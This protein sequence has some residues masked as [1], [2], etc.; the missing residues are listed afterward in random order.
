MSSLGEKTVHYEQLL[1][2]N[3]KK[4]SDEALD[5]TKDLKKSEQKIC[6]SLYSVKVMKEKLDEKVKRMKELCDKM[7]YNE[8]IYKKFKEQ[9]AEISSFSEYLDAISPLG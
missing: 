2:E 9:I 6:E 3:A 4:L 1:R 8:T 5:S 7:M